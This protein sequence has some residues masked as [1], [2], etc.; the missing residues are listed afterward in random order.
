[1]R[2]AVL[3]A[4]GATGKLMIAAALDR[5]LP[6]T[7]LARRP[8]RVPVRPGL[9]VVAADVRDPGSI[10]AALTETDV[11]LSGLG[12]SNSSGTGT[13][14]AGAQAVV[15]AGVERI[16]WLGALGTGP[17]AAAA[18]ALTRAMLGVLMRHEL[19][20]KI[21]ADAAVL[22]AGGTVFHVGPMTAG[23]DAPDRQTRSL[24]QAPRRLFPRGVSRATVAAAMVDEAV[25]HRFPGQIVTVV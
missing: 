17:S 10:A 4:T 14:T 21:A 18:G 22:A 5:A 11:L 7:A 20:D 24:E 2:I 8:E 3:G 19:P 9:T 12:T 23:P 15:A 6:V 25:H 16:I 13:L 1:M